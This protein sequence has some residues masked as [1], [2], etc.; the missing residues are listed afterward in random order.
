M[1]RLEAEAEAERL[2]GAHPERKHF[3]WTALPSREGVWSVVKI[4]A[5]RGARL[6]PLTAT[7][8]AKP[9]P[10]QADDPRSN[11]GRTLPSHGV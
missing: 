3:Q 8:E 4:P 2:N 6:E 5:P 11:L 7:T 10:P 9:K 1:T